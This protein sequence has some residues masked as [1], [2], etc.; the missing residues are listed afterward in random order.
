MFDGV[1]DRIIG[2][3]IDEFLSFF[4]DNGKPNSYNAYKVTRN[5]EKL[6]GIVSGGTDYEAML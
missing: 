1:W 2:L 5:S 3:V 4:V 6:L